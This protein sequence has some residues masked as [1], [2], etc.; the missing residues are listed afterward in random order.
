MSIT[1][2]IVTETYEMGDQ[3]RTSYG[4]AAYSDIEPSG[5]ACVLYAAR[6]LSSEREVLDILVDKLNRSEA[7]EIHFEDFINDYLALN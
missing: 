1:Y 2:G 4:I 5:T 7:S 6:D 3:K